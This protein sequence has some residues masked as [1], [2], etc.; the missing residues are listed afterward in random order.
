MFNR[1][2]C[3]KYAATGVVRCAVVMLL[4]V[5]CFTTFAQTHAPVDGKDYYIHP[6]KSVGLGA[7]YADKQPQTVVALGHTVYVAENVPGAR[8]V[9]RRFDAVSGEELPQLTVASAD[10]DFFLVKDEAG[11][12]VLVFDP[13]NPD[14]QLASDKVLNIKYG[15]LD[16]ADGTIDNVKVHTI[17]YNAQYSWIAMGYPLV[18]GDITTD[19]YQL[20]VPMCISYISTGVKSV[21][22]YRLGADSSKTSRIAVDTPSL[23]GLRPYISAVGSDHFLLDDN[24]YDVRLYRSP[25]T[26][27]A[28]YADAAHTSGARVFDY[29]HRHFLIHG[30]D[31]GAYAISNWKYESDLNKE[32]GDVTSQLT[33]IT[34]CFIVQPSVDFA[35]S[36]IATSSGS[37]CLSDMSY[38]EL[39]DGGVVSHIHLYSPGNYLATYQLSDRQ[40][41]ESFDAVENVIIDTDDSVEY[42][43]MQGIRVG[44]PIA[45]QVYIMRRGT[46]A[47]KIIYR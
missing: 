23:K 41:V 21:R 8:G 10:A 42:Y 40:E 35:G 44:C 17:S 25:S 14:E 38:F 18:M 37:R 2:L 36:R 4:M 3:L 15:C 33:G 26:V 20:M 46:A 30:T 11:H 34:G 9:I 22:L 39:P 27:I 31:V 12:I 7:S 47:T 24:Q 16:I 13:K 1:L 28:G 6:I 19:S 45:G 29:D 43:N 32:S 5:S